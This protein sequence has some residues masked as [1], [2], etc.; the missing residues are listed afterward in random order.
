MAAVSGAVPASPPPATAAPVPGW[1]VPERLKGA[2]DE[3]IF[4][5]NLGLLEKLKALGA[6]YEATAFQVD[7]RQPEGSALAR[8]QTAYLQERGCSVTALSP[9]ESAAT[10]GL[11]RTFAVYKPDGASTPFLEI[12]HLDSRFSGMG[13]PVHRPDASSESAR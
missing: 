6:E 10:L 8:F 11:A 7:G 12:E 1:P 3:E 4:S 2:S 9:L 13:L 5:S